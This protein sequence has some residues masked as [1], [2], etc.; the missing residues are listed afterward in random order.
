MPA[1]RQRDMGK[2]DLRRRVFGFREHVAVWRVA[3][4]VAAYGTKI[5]PGFFQIFISF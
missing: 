5:Y 4:C 1:R 2:S 3:G